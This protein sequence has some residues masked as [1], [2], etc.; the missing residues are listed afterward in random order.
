MKITTVLLSLLLILTAGA[1]VDVWRDI[2]SVNRSIM[3]MLPQA[4]TVQ[5]SLSGA[6]TPSPTATPVPRR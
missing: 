6:E 3:A 2:P 5:M 1:F 4:E